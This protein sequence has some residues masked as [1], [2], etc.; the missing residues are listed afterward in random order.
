MQRWTASTADL[1]AAAWTNLTGVQTRY[2]LAGA[3]LAV[4]ALIVLRAVRPTY[5][6]LLGAMRLALQDRW[7]TH[8]DATLFTTFR[9]QLDSDDAS[10]RVITDV[11]AHLFRMTVVSG[12]DLSELTDTDFR[13]CRAGLL[14]AGRRSSL[15]LDAAWRLMRQH[16]L[17]A[18]QPDELTHALARENS[19]PPSSSTATACA[20]RA[21][22]ICS[23]TTSP[24]ENPAATTPP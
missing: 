7:S 23:S 18:G 2:E 4:E 16:G 13:D 11:L 6:W 5:E 17:L 3:Q 20:I 8:H 12:H 19:P 22:E 10:T 21:S 1:Q 24:N 15:N 14:R 9:A